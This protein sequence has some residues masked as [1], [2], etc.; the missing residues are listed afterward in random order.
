MSAIMS[1]AQ[2]PRFELAGCVHGPMPRPRA[3]LST[4]SACRGYSS[5][6]RNAWAIVLL[7]LTGQ[8]SLGLLHGLLPPPR[9][10]PG[11]ALP[12]PRPAPLRLLSSSPR[13]WGQAVV[14]HVADRWEMLPETTA[15]QGP[16]G[17]TG[18][19]AGLQT[20]ALYQ[21]PT[22]AVTKSHRRCG[23]RRHRF[24]LL[25]FRR[26]EGCTGSCWRPAALRTLCWLW[27]TSVPCPLQLL[28]AAAFLGL[29]TL[30]PTFEIIPPSASVVTSPLASA[31][32]S[33]LQPPLRLHWTHLDNPAWSPQLQTL[34]YIRKVPFAT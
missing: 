34:N 29:W 16:W 3:P 6:D 5:G 30:P 22:C 21:L 33:P 17:S 15:W 25:Q 1:R 24:I 28:T 10:R 27:G 31:S 12:A 2:G 4:Y 8:P 32:P 19:Y 20:E 14:T 18:V 11:D 26:A 9:G 7:S 23:L 13:W